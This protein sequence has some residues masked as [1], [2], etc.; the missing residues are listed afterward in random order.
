MG[1]AFV[2]EKNLRQSS[3]LT[4]IWQKEDPTFIGK[5]WAAER[6]HSAP[7]RAP[8]QKTFATTASS[9]SGSSSRLRSATYVHK[10]VSVEFLALIAGPAMDICAIPTPSH[11]QH[12]QKK[13]F[14]GLET[15]RVIF[16]VSK[17]ILRIVNSSGVASFI[18]K[19]CY[20]KKAQGLCLTFSDH[21]L[22]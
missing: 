11:R 17:R 10:L 9:S 5:Q 6:I 22:Q 20:F 15:W 8:P 19:K 12:S 3:I 18:Q 7:I 21:I 2:S 16:H 13:Y 14:L 4:A 1:L